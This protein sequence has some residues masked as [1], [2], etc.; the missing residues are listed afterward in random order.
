[1]KTIEN[2]VTFD[3]LTNICSEAVANLKRDSR[4]KHEFE[5]VLSLMTCDFENMALSRFADEDYGNTKEDND[6]ESCL[7]LLPEEYRQ[8]VEEKAYSMGSKWQGEG[9]K[10]GLKTGIYFVLW[11]LLDKLRG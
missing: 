11:M 6:F 9:F 3:E 10:M 4:L 2:R 5:G 1:M 7:A 8:E